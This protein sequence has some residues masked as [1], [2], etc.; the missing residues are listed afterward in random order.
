MESHRSLMTT[1]PLE[2][3]DGLLTAERDHALRVHEDRK[4]AA[5]ERAL[6]VLHHDPEHYGLCEICGRQIDPDRLRIVP[7]TRH[8]E[9]DAE[10]QPPSERSKGYW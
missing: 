1:Y 2:L 7:A 10:R 4:L 9:D 5:V 6:D 3:F 8:C